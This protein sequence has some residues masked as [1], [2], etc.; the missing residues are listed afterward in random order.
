MT[1]VGPAPQPLDVVTMFLDGERVVADAIADAS[2]AAAWDHPSVL[3]D[4]TVSGLAGHLARGAVWGVAD[5]LDA[6][7][8]T[9]PAD[10][11]SAGEYFAVVVG[12]ASPDLHRAVRERGAA[13]GSIGH[14]ALARTLDE[15]LETLGPRLRS[16]DAGH[17]IAVV[18]GKVMRLDDYLVTRIVEQ[19][20]HLDD[21]ARSVDHEPWPTPLGAQE[22]AITVGIDIA[23]RRRGSGAVVRALYRQGFAEAA[24]PVL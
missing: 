19:V 12:M 8:P 23:Q 24:L 2:V 10:F 18:F 14:K 3:E 1:A 16:L 11:G 5:Y 7:P 13:V 17:I 15:R 22:L 21:L 9:G 4:Q 6:G 20:V